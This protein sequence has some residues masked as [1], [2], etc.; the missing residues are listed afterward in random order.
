MTNR[1]SQA[2]SSVQDAAQIRQ[3]AMDQ[4]SMA[5]KV[6][7]PLEL[8][9]QAAITSHTDDYR[10]YL[11]AARSR[12]ASLRDQINTTTTLISIILGDRREETDD[13][14]VDDHPS[15]KEATSPAVNGDQAIINLG[16]ITNRRIQKLLHIT[17]QEAAKIIHRLLNSKQI[18]LSPGST[19]L[20]TTTPPRTPNE[21]Q[22]SPPPQPAAPPE[23]AQQSAAPA[24]VA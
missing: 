1:E 14:Q 23:P 7:I 17:P 24:A 16:E 11:D 5:A 21:S 9:Y 22:A 19:K 13:L 18:F 15:N 4:V 3:R 6:L 10:R 2:P 8:A 12:L 20:Y